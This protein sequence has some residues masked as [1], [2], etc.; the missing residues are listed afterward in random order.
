[1]VDVFE[2]MYYSDIFVTDKSLI[3]SEEYQK[4]NQK[5]MDLSDKFEETL[6]EEDKKHFNVVMESFVS[7]MDIY[8]KDVYRQGVMLGL[9]L[10]AEAVSSSKDE[11]KN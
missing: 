1:M 7:A 5:F 8:C 9:R 4:E 6:S 3:S 11:L 10:M 2:K